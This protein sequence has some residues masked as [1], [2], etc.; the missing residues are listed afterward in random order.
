VGA[1][2]EDRDFVRRVRELA[3]AA[4]VSRRFDFPGVLDDAALDDVYAKADVL[5]LPS[6]SESYGMVVIEALARGL[7]VLATAVGGVPEALGRSPD[8]ERP[9][10]LV[11]PDDPAALAAAV[12]SWLQDPM[13]RTRLRAAA[14][15]R[16][17]TL[18]DWNDAARDLSAVLLTGEQP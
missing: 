2:D 14:R 17:T 7:P 8:D 3:E 4:G 12:R 10:Q 9:G 18:R 13:E 6:R 5:V 1:L 11:A 16:S 15:Q